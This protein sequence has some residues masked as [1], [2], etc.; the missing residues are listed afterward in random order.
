MRIRM[1]ALRS[2]GS[3]RYELD[4]SSGTSLYLKPAFGSLPGEANRAIPGPSTDPY[5]GD[6]EPDVELHDREHEKVIDA[7]KEHEECRADA[8]GPEEESA[9]GG[10]G[11]RTGDA[12][13]LDESR[14]P[15]EE[16]E[17]NTG[18]KRRGSCGRD[19]IRKPQYTVPDPFKDQ[20]WKSVSNNTHWVEN[21]PIITMVS[22]PMSD[23]EVPIACEIRANVGRG[24]MSITFDT[25]DRLVVVHA[26]FACVAVL[27]TAP[28]AALAG[29]YMRRRGW[30]ACHRALNTATV[31]LIIL[32]FALG[33][34]AV[35]SQ[36]QGTQ[37]SGPNRDLHHDLG[38]A[39]FII[40]VLQG[41]SGFAASFTPKG[42]RGASSGGVLMGKSSFRWCHIIVGIVVMGLLYAEAWIG[43][44]E[45]NTM[46]STGTFTPDAVRYIFLIIMGFEIVAYLYEAGRAVLL[47][48]AGDDDR[49]PWRKTVENE[50]ALP[51]APAACQC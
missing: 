10:Q 43:F 33:T 1:R 47:A 15:G 9:G 32:V 28:A 6:E 50:K 42:D 13:S 5:D 39:M 40:V 16:E 34:A 21:G 30:F 25:H 29:R 12:E 4:P 36:G 18:A 49:G 38:L 27:G 3:F 19:P 45:W 31:L 2:V 46:Q 44:D 20:W 37:F 14:G 24:E 23:E 48:I 26:V 11:R 8:F 7:A 35:N 51:S 22:L 41:I 17:A